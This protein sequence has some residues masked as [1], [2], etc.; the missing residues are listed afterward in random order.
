MKIK[1]RTQGIKKKFSY[2]RLKGYRGLRFWMRHSPCWYCCCCCVCCIDCLVC[3][4]AKL[5]LHRTRRQRVTLSK[6]E[7]AMDD[8]KEMIKKG[9]EEIVFSWLRLV[10]IYR[11]EK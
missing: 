3:L 7:L 2:G 6:E 10:G 4:A 1:E 5:V 8:Q 9:C 11:R